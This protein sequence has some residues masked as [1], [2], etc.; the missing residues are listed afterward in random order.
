M[1][2]LRILAIVALVAFGLGSARSTDAA[3]FSLTVLKLG[4]GVGT[5]TSGAGLDCGNTCSQSYS[6]ATQVTLAATPS[7]GSV[8]VGWSGDCQG[9]GACQVM[10][11]STVNVVAYFRVEHAV[12]FRLYSDGTK[13]HL[14]TTDFVEYSQL[15][16]CC[17]WTPEGAIYKVLKGPGLF[18]GVGGVPYY[19]LYN[20]YSFQHHWTSDTNEYN[21]LP[22]V[23][24]IQEGIDG[25]ILP[26]Q[27]Q[28]ALPLYRLYLNAAGGLHLWTIDSN[29]VDYLTTTSGWTYEGL[30]GYVIPLGRQLA[31]PNTSALHWGALG[32]P[33]SYYLPKNPAGAYGTGFLQQGSDSQTPSALTIEWAISKIPDDFSYYKS[34]AASTINERGAQSFPCGG[35]NGANGGSYY[36]SLTGSFSECKVD[37]IGPWFLSVRY[38]D[39]CLPGALCPVAYFHSEN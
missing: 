19:R 25:Y 35:V 24:W 21:S 39:N 7:A 15:P 37:S 22:G 3:Q 16:Q 12:R 4:T 5:V 13:E 23:G 27:A 11:N 26:R 29:E 31:Q 17:A 8:F 2:L 20:P 9:T 18:S 38:I 6:G 30:A 10:V 36:W 28:G 34:D 32:E 14:Y 1:A 33:Y